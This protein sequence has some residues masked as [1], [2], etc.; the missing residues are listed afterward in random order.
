MKRLHTIRAQRVI[1]T[2]VISANDNLRNMSES[3]DAKKSK[4]L[5]MEFEAIGTTSYLMA[6]PNKLP[7]GQTRIPLLPQSRHATIS[8]Y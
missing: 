7:N 3:Q 1:K 5:D 2:Q 8:R 6:L 4:L